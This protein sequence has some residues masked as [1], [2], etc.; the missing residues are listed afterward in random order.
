MKISI[1]TPNFNG[2][3]WLAR[4]MD[5]VLSQELAPDDELEY[6]VVDGCNNVRKLKTIRH[7]LHRNIAGLENTSGKVKARQG[8]LCR[9][10]KRLS[11]RR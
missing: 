5:S 1:L 9:L 4:C 3:Q 7:R 8:F 10:Q 6:I 2:T 11:G